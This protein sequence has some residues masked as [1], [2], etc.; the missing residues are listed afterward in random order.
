MLA[1]LPP[2]LHTQIYQLL[3]RTSINQVSLTCRA[4]YAS[5]LPTLYSTLVLYTNT[6]IRRL[7][8]RLQDDND[9]LL[10]QVIRHCTNQLV[11][12]CKQSGQHRL[13]VDIRPLLCH[14]PHLRQ[15]TFMHFHTLPVHYI[16]PLLSSLPQ[17]KQVSLRYCDLVLDHQKDIF[18]KAPL[19]SVTQLELYWTDFNKPAIQSTLSLFPSLLHIQLLANHNR[20]YMA[21]NHAVDLLQQTCPHIT[22]LS[23][24]LQEVKEHTLVKCITSFG[25]QLQGISLQCHS[26][27]TLLAITKHA[28]LVQDLTIRFSLQT[29]WY[30]PPTPVTRSPR[31]QQGN[32]EE[33][34]EEFKMGGL[35]SVLYHCQRLVRVQVESRCPSP[36]GDGDLPPIVSKALATVAQKR[37]TLRHTQGT[38]HN[39]IIASNLIT[40]HGTTF[41]YGD[42]KGDKLTATMKRADLVGHTSS[43][44]TTSLTATTTTTTTTTTT[45][46]DRM[47]S[48]KRSSSF[49][50]ETILVL[51]DEQL[52]EIRSQ[53]LPLI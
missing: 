33:D 38:M 32:H 41:D 5:A 35:L 34:E 24:G 19:N 31:Q 23:I 37:I 21:N 4:L 20:H 6:H 36:V 15:L 14:L 11:L 53:V 18:D 45:N 22:N 13:L 8:T 1:H 2:E 42:T 47:S 30:P 9:G 40:Q 7:E 44:H 51:D 27:S 48:P 25:P 17:L 46:N 26:P 49:L 39:N 43:R 12:Q 3:P 28:P 50:M 16:R 52:K 29:N 10:S